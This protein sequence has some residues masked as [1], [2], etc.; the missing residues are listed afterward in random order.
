MSSSAPLPPRARTNST[1]VKPKPKKKR[2]PRRFLAFLFLFLIVVI[3]ALA[4]YV[5]DLW[6][7]T[8]QALKDVALPEGSSKP[9]ASEE[10]AQVKPLSLLLLGTDYR[11]E[12]GSM[13]TDVVMVIAMNPQSN[14]AT[15]VSIPRDTNPQ[16]KGYKAQKI[17]AFYAGFHSKAPKDQDANAYARDEMRTMMGKMFDITVDY[18][19]VMNF[20]GFSDVIDAL[21]GV[22]VYVDQNM[23][24]TDS[25]DGTDINLKK[26]EQTLD[27][28]NALDFVRYRKSNHGTA[29]SSDF[30]RNDRQ[31]RVLAAIIDKMKS[32]GGVAKLGN[33]IGAVGDNMRTDIPRDQIIN[34]L[35][36][37][38]DI[39][40]E[41]VRFLPLEG[42]WDSPY[43][44]LNDESLQQAKAALA[45]E[46]QPEGRKVQASASASASASAAGE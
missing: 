42:V 17:N 16:L 12:T 41:S 2:R 37:Y 15:V 29:A 27:G 32:V 4:V 33:V 23:R 6:R 8:N 9:I 34:M 44:Y 5:G 20:Q 36:A 30:D 3:A 14:T 10:R 19:A 7:D 38:Y 39:D 11:K 40:K 1:K 43:V 21:G 45:E 35:K 46:L 26:G 31:S 22:K 13:N 28:K 25:V 24:Y 18:A